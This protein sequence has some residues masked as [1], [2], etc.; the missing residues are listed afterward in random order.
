[1]NRCSWRSSLRSRLDKPPGQLLDCSLTLRQDLLHHDSIVPLCE[2]KLNV[3]KSLALATVVWPDEY[4]DVRV[5]NL[6]RLGETR[7]EEAANTDF[8]AHADSLV[9]AGLS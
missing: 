9:L 3:S 6:D 8:E 2:A 7:E 4:D 1:M 5:N